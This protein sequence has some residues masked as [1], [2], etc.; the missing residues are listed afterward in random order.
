MRRTYTV[1]AN[2]TNTCT[3]HKPDIAKGQQITSCL[4]IPSTQQLSVLDQKNTCLP[5]GNLLE[6]EME[7]AVDRLEKLLLVLR[8]RLSRFYNIRQHFPAIDTACPSMQH[9]QTHPLTHAHINTH[10]HKYFSTHTHAHTHDTPS[11]LSLCAAAHNGTRRYAHTHTSTHL[12]CPFAPPHKSLTPHLLSPLPH[13]T[14]HSDTHT[15]KNTHTS[16]HLV[17]PFEPPHKSLTPHLLSPL[18]H[19]TVHTHTNMT[20]HL[21]CPFVQPH[22]SLTPHLLG[23][24]PLATAHP[25]SP[26]GCTSSLAFAS[27]LHLPARYKSGIGPDINS[28]CVSQWLY[29]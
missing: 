12:A 23:P 8:A 21:A 22:K 16:T 24:I 1:P 26:S 11:G 5:L 7:S 18:P 29:F 6:I 10:T 25:A 19:T 28:L 27:H 9:A 17:C 3:Q 13:A 15:Y 4:C 2:P 20:P 14:A